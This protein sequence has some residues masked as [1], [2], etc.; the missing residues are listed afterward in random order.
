M[1]PLKRLRKQTGLSAYAFSKR[2]GMASQNYY[3]LERG[4]AGRHE[5]T[6]VKL[7]RALAELLERSPTDVLA[8][9]TEVE[10]V[11]A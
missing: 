6:L 11:A 3:V 1:S 8:E 7:A 5:D 10:E 9:L 2:L 4:E